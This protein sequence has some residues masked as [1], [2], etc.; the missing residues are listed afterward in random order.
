MLEL[1]PQ[2]TAEPASELRQAPWSA[3]AAQH[4]LSP[5][6]AWRILCKRTGGGISRATFYRWVSCGRVYSVRLGFHIFI[7][8]AALEDLIK[9]CLAG[10]RF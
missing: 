1:A 10:E 3:D 5:Q 9:Q 8:Q 2:R 7:P 4:M 6:A